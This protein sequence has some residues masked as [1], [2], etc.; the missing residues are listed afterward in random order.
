MD[1]IAPVPSAPFVRPSAPEMGVPASVG[2]VPA[3]EVVTPVGR[4]RRCTFRRI[5]GVTALPGRPSTTTSYEVMCLYAADQA[6]ALGDL[7][8]ARSACEACSA[9]GIFRPDE[10]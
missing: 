10:D 8:D 6:M 1:A 9:T 4:M 7:A 2:D 5:D 3:P